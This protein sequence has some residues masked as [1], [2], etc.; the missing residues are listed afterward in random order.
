MKK[1]LSLSNHNKSEKLI[2]VYIYEVQFFDSNI[3]NVIEKL[4]NKY[5][6]NVFA[7]G[8]NQTFEGKPFPFKDKKDHICTLMALSDKVI[9]L[10]AICNNCGKVATRTYRLGESKDTVVIGGINFYQARCNN[11][12]LEK[13]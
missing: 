5:R 3:I 1:E 8:L 2:N 7:C 12:F 10:D 13:D 11:C 6:I 4:R 9:S